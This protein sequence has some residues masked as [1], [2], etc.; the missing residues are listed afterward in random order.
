MKEGSPEMLNPRFTDEIRQLRN[1]LAAELP[2]NEIGLPEIDGHEEEILKIAHK[3]FAD[4]YTNEDIKAIV[5]TLL[6]SEQDA[7]QRADDAASSLD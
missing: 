3:Y 7:S 5:S 4:G 1:Q 6:E 2:G